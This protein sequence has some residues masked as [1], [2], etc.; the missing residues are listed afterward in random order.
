MTDHKIANKCQAEVTKLRIKADRD[1][2]CSG[3]DTYS[4]WRDGWFEEL[5]YCDYVMAS[6][7][8]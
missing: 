2:V 8:E 1:S 6:E 4:M 5:K 7:Y 3:D